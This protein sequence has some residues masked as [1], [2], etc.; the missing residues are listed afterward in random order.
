MQT[1]KD[2]VSNVVAQM[3]AHKPF[4]GIDVGEVWYKVS[5][6][7]REHTKVRNFS[8]GRMLVVVDSPARIFKLT[9]EKQRILQSLQREIPQLK[10]IEFKVGKIS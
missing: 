8:D 1:I 5:S 10:T 4:E 7:S 9:V 2:I 6:E 3:A